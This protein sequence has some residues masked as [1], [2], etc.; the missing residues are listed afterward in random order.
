MERRRA[1]GKQASGEE[2]VEERCAGARL[3]VRLGNPGVAVRRRA[4]QSTGPVARTRPRRSRETLTHTTWRH[5]CARGR[6]RPSSASSRWA[7]FVPGDRVHRI[8][9]K[10]GQRR[11]G[12]ASPPLLAARVKHQPRPA[13]S[14]KVRGR[15][16]REERWLPRGEGAKLEAG[17][18]RRGN[19]RGSAVT[20]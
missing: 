1:S 16:C 3:R 14:F 12:I 8:L 15:A 5:M 4:G 19:G 20:E 18:G 9:S 17:D 6:R 10:A 11:L 13:S 7:T 2:K